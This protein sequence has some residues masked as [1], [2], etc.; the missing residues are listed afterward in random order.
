MGKWAEVHC[1]CP[2]HVPLA[3]S[4]PYF[5]KPHYKKHRLTK[6][7]REEVEEW[8][9]ATKDMFACGHRRGTLIELSPGSRLELERRLDEITAMNSFAGTALKGIVEQSQRPDLES[10]GE[11][12]MEALAD[13]AK[14]CHVS[15]STGNPI[16][17]LW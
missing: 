6:K 14:L 3:A 11:K 12:V 8:E 9:R 13:A 10:T 16:R 2:N 5:G 17:L 7:E 1:N 15:I 4:D